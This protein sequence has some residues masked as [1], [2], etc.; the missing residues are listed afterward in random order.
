VLHPDGLVG[1]ALGVLLVAALVTALY[2][3]SIWI[4]DRGSARLA[5]T[6][7]PGRAR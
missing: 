3:F 7:L 4:G 5:L 1:A 2:A 6:K